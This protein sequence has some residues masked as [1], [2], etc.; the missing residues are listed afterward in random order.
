MF[1]VCEIGRAFGVLAG[2][3]TTQPE[4]NAAAGAIEIERPELQ[5][6]TEVW[7]YPDETPAPEP[8]G[9][10]LPLA[11]QPNISATV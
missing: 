3:Y 2:P 7:N 4:A 1:Y 10:M 6:R 8:I 5:A 9:I 11:A